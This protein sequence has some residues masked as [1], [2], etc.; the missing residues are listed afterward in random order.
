MRYRRRSRS[1]FDPGDAAADIT[2]AQQR[3]D[4]SMLIKTVLAIAGPCISFSTQLCVEIGVNKVATLGLPP[5]AATSDFISERRHQRWSYQP[6]IAASR[7][8]GLVNRI[9][10]CLNR[11]IMAGSALAF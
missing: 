7:G 4:I 8:V 9:S 5:V 6:V 11:K 1:E 2:K 10:N 3:E